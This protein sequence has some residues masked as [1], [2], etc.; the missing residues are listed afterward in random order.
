[1]SKNK[2]VNIHQEMSK[3][4]PAEIVTNEKVRGKQNEDQER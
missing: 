4:K 3:G 2:N 1:M